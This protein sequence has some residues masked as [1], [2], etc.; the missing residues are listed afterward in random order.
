MPGFFFLSP[1]QIW[2]SLF[3]DE[4]M[5]AL[6][7]PCLHRRLKRKLIQHS[8]HYCTSNKPKDEIF[9]RSVCLPETGLVV[10]FFELRIHEQVNFRTSRV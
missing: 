10:A 1:L 8:L 9:F 3:S 6:S 4:I 5:A 2:G 7:S